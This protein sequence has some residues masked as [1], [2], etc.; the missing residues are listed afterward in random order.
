VW[1]VVGLLALLLAPS[2]AAG[3]L[4]EA[5][6]RKVRFEG[7]NTFAGDSLARA[8]VTR[9]TECKSLVFEPFCWLGADWAEQKYYLRQAIVP[10]DM[11]RLQV[12]YRRRGFRDTQ[13]DTA[14]IANA[15][16]S[17]DVLFRISE[18]RPVLVDS[19]E[20]LGAE[21]FDDIGLLDELPLEVGDALND[22]LLDA[23]QETIRRRL[24]NEGYAHA[25]VLK[26][27]IIPSETPFQALV[28][29][30]VA[31]GPRSRYGHIE[32]TVTG[33]S[34]DTASASLTTSTVLKTLQFRAGDLYR[35]DQRLDAQARLYGLE[36]VRSA[37]VEV[38]SLVTAS[39]SVIPLDVHVQEGDVHRV[40]AGG[41]WSSA[42][43]F[44]VE[45]RWIS[46]N[47]QGGGRRLQVRGRLSNLGAPQFHTILCPQLDEEP[48]QKLSWLAAVDFAQPWIFSTRNSFSASLYG[49]RQSIPDAFVREA[50]GLSL[51]LTR[52]IGPRTPLTLSYQPELSRLDAAEVLFCTSF[53]VCSPD[54][55]ASLQGANWL[56]PVGINFSRNSANNILNPTRGYTMVIDLEHAAPWT[57]SDF[58]YDRAIIDGAV[59]ERMT[60]SSVLAARLRAGWVGAGAFDEFLG[61]E[62]RA[63]VEGV[64]P[65]KRFYG[66]GA[67]SVRGFAQSRLGPLV[68]TADPE[69]LMDVGGGGAGCSPEEVMSLSCNAEAIE[70]AAFLPRPTGGTR[71]LEGSVEARFPLTSRL[72][73][74]AFADFGQVWG[75]DDVVSLGSTEVAPGVGLRVMS[76][77]GP[78]RLDVAYRFL[79]GRLLPLVTPQIRPFI[80][81]QDDLGDRISVDG[82]K[83]EYVKTEELVVLTP[84]V[85]WGESPALSLRRFQIHISIGQAF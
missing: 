65:Q 36:I 13:V 28:S 59:Y 68:L 55:I 69:L 54:D 77:I 50:L 14:T 27:F 42:E 18:G 60:P 66:G 34:G 6:I 24:Q 41:G 2:H 26:S 76:P 79:G 21:G 46:R 35:L 51:A 72:Q 74:V 10:V 3:Q 7:N 56:S 64:H 5:Q 4:G 12:W 11:L 80:P 63:S 31:P 40:R 23:T 43:C 15:D 58:R 1:A 84:L 22:L 81:G 78:I 57:G 49:E 19:I 48:F 70:D 44:D 29:Y 71:V 47:F 37:R 33:E 30:D 67:N 62:N 8:I 61:I 83:I 16:G 82:E 85:L 9:E 25:D 38:D 75:G 17:A 32:V 45:S 20:I 39:D 73:G 52:N 53:L